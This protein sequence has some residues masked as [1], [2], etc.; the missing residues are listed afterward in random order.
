MNHIESKNLANMNHILQLSE[1]NISNKK[2]GQPFFQ[3]SFPFLCMAGCVLQYCGP[4]GG[5]DSSP[6]PSFKNYLGVL[7][8]SQGSFKKYKF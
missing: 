2:R 6:P 5:L 1:T 7:A 4:Q 8:H 3:V